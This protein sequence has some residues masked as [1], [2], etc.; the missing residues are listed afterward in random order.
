[1]SNI[2]DDILK[3][4]PYSDPFLFV[5]KVVE[6]DDTNIIGEYCFSEDRDFYRGHFINNPITPGVLIVESFAQIGGVA[7][8]IYLL[9]LFKKDFM[10]AF[11]NA[12]FEFFNTLKPGETI[13][14]YSKKVVLRKNYLKIKG[15]V[16]NSK[17]ELIMQATGSCKFIVL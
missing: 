4:L 10:P 14:V 2:C 13:Y 1:M 7:H 9:D 5:D 17:N 15:E 11:A 3:N 6:I 16:F 8:G 12:S